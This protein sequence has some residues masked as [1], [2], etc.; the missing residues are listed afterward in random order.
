MKSYS[1]LFCLLTLLATNIVFAAENAGRY[2]LLTASIES[3]DGGATTKVFKLDTATGRSW[4]YNLG[5]SDSDP[6]GEWLEIGGGG[7]ASAESIPNPVVSNPILVPAL[8][9]QSTQLPVAVAPALEGF[10]KATVVERSEK[11]IRPDSVVSVRKQLLQYNRTI[12]WAMSHPKGDWLDDGKGGKAFV[13]GEE[14][15]KLLKETESKK[16]R[17]MSDLAENGLNPLQFQ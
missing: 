6:A 15:D 13:S 8:G 16:K 11:P 9:A 5:G 10:P 12:Q 14:I 3:V 17:L 1:T 7:E 2:Q 4:V